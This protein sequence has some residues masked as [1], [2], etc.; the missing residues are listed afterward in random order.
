M[1]TGDEI[2]FRLSQSSEEWLRFQKEYL[3]NEQ[4]INIVCWNVEKT[5]LSGYTFINCDFSAAVMRQVN[6]DYCSFHNCTFSG[7]E[8]QYLSLIKTYFE[9]IE[10]DNF[11]IEDI[12]M[13]DGK[14]LEIKICNS[15]LEKISISDCCLRQ[16]T[17]RKVN[18]DKVRFRDS[19]FI[20]VNG[21]EN[22]ILQGEINSLKAEKIHLCHINMEEVTCT[23]LKIDNSIIEGGKIIKCQLKNA[24]INGSKL[25]SLQFEKLEMEQTDF[26]NGFLENIDLERF[27][28]EKIGLLHTTLLRC[29]WPEQRY[30][31]SA[32]GRYKKAQ[33]LLMQPVEDITG[34]SPKLRNEIKIAQ[35][36][37]E[38]YLSNKVWYS[39]IWSWF[40]GIT[41][42]YGRSLSR[43]TL[44]CVSIIFILMIAFFFSYPIANIK[45][46]IDTY[47]IVSCKNV[48]LSFVGISGVD[49]HTLNYAQ[50]TILIV[51]RIFGVIF[52]GLWVGVAANKIGSIG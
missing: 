14:S 19:R 13:R 8:L 25:S 51:D 12:T 47:L 29:R 16:L 15:H 18:V 41:T 45:Q 7:C 1:E 28:I 4:R 24:Y 30:T 39:K 49:E 32:L 38:T 27:S 43:L 26:F 9:K 42:E 11:K 21:Y 10:F 22:G 33:H 6:L 17:I 46:S 50:N 52:T 37:E 34:I 44:V 20:E 23:G 2:L 36:V 5:N 31:V 48:L 40:W 3:Q 35:L